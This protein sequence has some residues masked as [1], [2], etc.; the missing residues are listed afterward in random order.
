MHLMLLHYNDVTIV[1][2]LLPV[3]EDWLDLLHAKSNHYILHNGLPS[4]VDSGSCTGTLS[5]VMGTAFFYQQVI[6][7]PI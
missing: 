1:K 5:S 2:Q 7:L 3:A 4:F 6:F